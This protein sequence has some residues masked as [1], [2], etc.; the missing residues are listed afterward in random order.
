MR[1]TKRK[2]TKADGG[3]SRQ[4]ITSGE[5]TVIC[6]PQTAKFQAE[7]LSPIVENDSNE[8]DFYNPTHLSSDAHCKRYACAP[9]RL[10]LFCRLA[11]FS[12]PCAK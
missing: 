9:V 2:S 7:N 4:L 11:F 3:S 5:L 6:Q 12:S 8:L 1:F 10:K